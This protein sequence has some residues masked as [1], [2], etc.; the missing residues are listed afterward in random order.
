MTAGEG[1]TLAGYLVGFAVFLWAARASGFDASAMLRLGAVALIAGAVGARI[2]QHA[3]GAGGIESALSTQAGGRTILAGVLCG[4]LAVEVAKRV[5]GLKRSTGAAFALALA[6][7]ECV[8]RVGCHFNECCYGREWGG[9]SVF[10]HGAERFPAQL[11]AAAYS[12]IVFMV[13]LSARPRLE[14][15][16][17]FQLYLALFAFGRFFL[18]FGREPTLV[19]AG[20]SA[21][22]WV[23]IEIAASLAAIQ[24]WKWST[25]RRATAQ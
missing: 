24:V 18:E 7:G 5:M 6:A 10:Q 2:A 20:L 16:A 25:S 23:C 19:F 4:W 17:L 8:G 12:G 22:Q 15:A 3:F 13:L 9:L 21:A 1:F 11:T 14:A